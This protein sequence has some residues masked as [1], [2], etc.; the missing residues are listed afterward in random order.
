MD[1]KSSDL[2]SHGVNLIQKQI[3]SRPSVGTPLIIANIL[4]GQ[5]ERGDSRLVQTPCLTT[6]IDYNAS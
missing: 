1:L 5:A 6:R 2:I 3:I 4:R